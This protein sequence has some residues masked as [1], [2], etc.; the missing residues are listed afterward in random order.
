[1]WVTFS[2]KEYLAHERAPEEKIKGLGLRTPR[3]NLSRNVGV[4]QPRG[5]EA[6]RRQVEE[7]ARFVVIEE[8]SRVA[9]D[10]VSV[11]LT[12]RCQPIHDE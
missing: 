8:S 4:G 6:L 5:R 1:M 3:R 2:S 10:A 11:Y 9:E 7:N 12:P